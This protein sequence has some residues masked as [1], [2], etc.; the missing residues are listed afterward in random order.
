M[1]VKNVERHIAAGLT[2][3]AAAHRAMEEVTGAVIV[4]AFELSAVFVPTASPR[5]HRVMSAVLSFRYVDFPQ[6]FAAAA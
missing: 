5:G 3:R 1:V 4:I 6:A 2:P